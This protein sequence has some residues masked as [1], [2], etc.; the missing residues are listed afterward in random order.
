MFTI[1]GADGK[2]YGPVATAKIHEWINGGRANLH[3]KA[4]RT[5]ESEWKTLG[6]F[7]EFNPT[8]GVVTPPAPVAVVPTL[9]PGSAADSLTPGPTLNLASRWLRLGAAFI[10][11]FLVWL[12]KLPIFF[13]VLPVMKAAMSDPQ[14]MKPEL[15]SEAVFGAL[16]QALPLLGLLAL[17]QILLLCFRSQS[18]GKLLLGMRIVSVQTGEPGGPLRAFLLR[19]FLPWIFE[20]IPLLGTLFWI[21]DVCFIFSEEKRCLHDLIAG[22]QVVKT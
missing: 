10:D 1:L 15:I 21:V 9:A 18:I 11:G 16:S 6:D 2:E 13:A 17:G 3:T 5:D 14:A 20:L 4:R 12:C 8:P 22:T 19:G 7:P